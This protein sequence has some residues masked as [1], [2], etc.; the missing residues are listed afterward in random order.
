MIA[1]GKGETGLVGFE[2]GR[3]YHRGDDKGEVDYELEGTG[4]KFR[5]YAYES[6]GEHLWAKMGEDRELNMFWK[7][8]N[9]LYLFIGGEKDNIDFKK[10]Y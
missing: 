5:I 2:H 3:G 1:A 6:Y 8:N 10:V 4:I 9:F 7:E